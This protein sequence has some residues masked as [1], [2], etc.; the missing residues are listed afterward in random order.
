MSDQTQA[1]GPGTDPLTGLATRAALDAALRALWHDFPPGAAPGALAVVNLDEFTLFDHTHGHVVGDAALRAFTGRLTAALPAGTVTARWGGGDAALLLPVS[2]AQATAL[3]ERLTQESTTRPHD[4]DGVLRLLP[5]S[6]GVCGL[7]AD[8]PEAVPAHAERALLVAKSRHRGSC[9]LHDG[10][11]DPLPTRRDLHA[12]VTALVAEAGRLRDDTLTDHLTGLPDA[13]ALE[14]A[15]RRLDDED[16]PYCVLFVD[17]DRFG[18]DNHAHGDAAGDAALRT[19]SRTLRG[20]C[21]PGEAVFRKGGEELV[22]LL[23][24]CTAVEALHVAERLRAAVE[25]LGL[26]HGGHPDSPVLTVTVAVADRRPGVPARDLLDEASRQAFGAKDRR[27]RNRVVPT[28][29][30]S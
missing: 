7:D 6:A 4:V 1:P 12:A 14:V 19:V 17:L 16:G 28:D 27:R 22:V 18:A 5:F 8:R 2:P 23:P 15:L 13:R 10:A 25:G 29:R 26:P 9:V 24:G 30:P 11:G 21:R 20:S 3:L